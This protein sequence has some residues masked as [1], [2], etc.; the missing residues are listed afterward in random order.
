MILQTDLR[1]ALRGSLLV[2]SP[3]EFHTPQPSYSKADLLASG[4]GG[5]FGPGN[6]QLPSPPML[7]MDRIVEISMDGGEY[8]NGFVAAE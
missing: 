4:R 3:H 5:Y 8:G 7:M 2:P 6:A 1:S